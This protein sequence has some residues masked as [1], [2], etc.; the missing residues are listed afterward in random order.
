MLQ[1]VPADTPGK[2]AGHATTN[3]KRPR[4][5]IEATALMWATRYG[6]RWVK[7]ML[8]FGAD[9]RQVT[10][11]G[12]SALLCGAVF[13][14]RG[15]VLDG[16]SDSGESYGG[17]RDR[18]RGVIGPLVDG[19]ASTAPTLALDL[20]LD[21]FGPTPINSPLVG[22]IDVAVGEAGSNIGWALEIR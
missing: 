18:T 17:Y 11:S 7:L 3:S 6:V 2:L 4:A 22:P 8:R 19:G 10:P 5:K 20:F 9:A 13:E 16:A 1:L 15:I 21:A 14:S 12:W